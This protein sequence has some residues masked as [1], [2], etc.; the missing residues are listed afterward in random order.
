MFLDS[1]ISIDKSKLDDIFTCFLKSLIIFKNSMKK[2]VIL[3]LMLFVAGVVAPAGNALAKDKITVSV[4]ENAENYEKAAKVSKKSNKDKVKN[5]KRRISKLKQL[6]INKP[7]S[8][9]NYGKDLSLNEFGS[10]IG[11]WI[12][13][14]WVETGALPTK[15]TNDPP[16]W[17]M[18]NINGTCYSGSKTCDRWVEG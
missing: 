14:V 6:G 12:V 2:L 8:Y 17:L 7:K 3:M 4:N 13:K 11:K 16:D 5:T 1:I 9:L 18:V 10:I 15:L